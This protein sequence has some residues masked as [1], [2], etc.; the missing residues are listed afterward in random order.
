MDTNLFIIGVAVFLMV[1]AIFIY[2]K[3]FR[4]E[5]SK[6][7]GDIDKLIS[8][9]ENLKQNANSENMYQFCIENFEDIKK[10]FE[11]YPTVKPIWQD[12]E[13]SLT[14]YKDDQ[15]EQLYSVV[16][17]AEYFSFH[18]FTQKI[19][20]TF[21]QGYGGTFTGLGILGTFFGLTFGLSQMDM[22]STDIE[23]LKGGI[24]KLLSGVQLAFV[25]S[26]FGI[27][28]AIG[29]GYWHNDTIKEFREQVQKLSSLIEEIF[30]RR[31]AEY[32]LHGNY[33]QST[34]QTKLLQT[35]G[36]DVSQAIFDGLDQ[37]LDDGISRLCD[38]IEEKITPMF[39]KVCNSIDK[40]GD[41]GSNAINET[42]ANF[43]GSQMQSFAN[44]LN[45]FTESV[46][47]SLN[48]SQKTGEK[49]NQII[50]ATLEEM[51]TAIKAGAEDA[52]NYQRES[53]KEN[54]ATI[55]QLVENMKTFTE[56]QK[57]LL[58]QF[59]ANNTSQIQA[60]TDAFQNSVFTHM[61]Q[62]LSASKQATEEVR[63]KFSATLDEM[64]QIIKNGTEDI[65]KNQ[66]ESI[67][68]SVTAVNALT[69]KLK[70]Y[71]ERQEQLLT[72]S[73][74]ESERQIKTTTNLLQSTL[75][76]HNSTMEKSCRQMETFMQ[77]TEKVLS[78]IKAAT[79]SLGQAAAPIQ[80]GVSLLRESLKANES[81]TKKFLDEISAQINRLATANQ[82]SEDNIETL[83]LELQ[84]YEKNI[85]RAWVN[86]EN[87]FNRVGGELERATN[88][89]TQ[90]LQ[91]YNNMMNNGMKQTLDKFD[92][93]VTAAVGSLN[94]AVEDLQDTVDSLTRKRS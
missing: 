35:I 36:T 31:T 4:G 89:I 82:K 32:W 17:A 28:F 64:Y 57:N 23:V 71:S 44:S 9:L 42:M 54:S 92:K 48:D 29:Y 79:T 22:T 38:Q 94:T 59:A 83:V 60:A 18:N 6:I 70:N 12:F 78:N 81:A 24:T 13:K 66:R 73:V 49:M 58:E 55:S 63:T 43:A 39:E 75:S 68:E 10:E 3:F 27:V 33:T 16:D 26:L 56:Q 53:V 67:N 65:S 25:T 77:D 14:R 30:P 40:L 37:R 93:S 15:T 61:Q 72:K 21:W 46:Q 69:E 20:L 80:Q 8:Y 2:V 88:I 5:L 11:K 91:D 1:G 19:N 87:N 74:A 76:R 86:Y 84:E 41:G 52:A 51:R 7:A 85:Q 47:K 90:R 34:E 45:N 62:T 50:M